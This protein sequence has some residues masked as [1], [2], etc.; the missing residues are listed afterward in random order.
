LIINNPPT[1]P[2]THML[3]VVCTDGVSV[4]LT[5]GITGAVK[6]PS[7]K[8]KKAA[9]DD[10]EAVDKPND[11]PTTQIDVNNLVKDGAVKYKNGLRPTRPLLERA[12]ITSDPGVR[13]NTMVATPTVL[14]EQLQRAARGEEIPEDYLKADDAGKIRG[15]RQHAAAVFSTIA[16]SAQHRTAERYAIKKVD[17]V[18]ANAARPTTV[19]ALQNRLQQLNHMTTLQNVTAAI[20]MRAS[21]APALLFAY[22]RPEF[23]QGRRDL[24]LGKKRFAEQITRSVLDMAQPVAPRIYQDKNGN[25][26]P[27]QYYPEKRS[28]IGPFSEKTDEAVPGAVAPD[29]QRAQA[30]RQG[31][32][33]GEWQL[34]A[35]VGQ[36]QHV[37]LGQQLSSSRAADDGRAEPHAPRQA[38]A[39]AR[40]LLLVQ[41]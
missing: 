39:G 31:L 25:D 2:A 13:E 37:A 8:K 19:A 17:K 6:P 34:V 26:L 30:A 15:N 16:R 11:L 38:Q 24:M 40:R 3:Q 5:Y 9:D 27:P 14:L 29:A 1:L 35:A 32:D 7:K 41:D 21:V 22:F 4:H 36:Q 20:S 28:A 18:L 10:D 12:Y 33:H 23:R